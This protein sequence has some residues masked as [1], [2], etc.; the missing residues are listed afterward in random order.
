MSK[1]QIIGQDLNG[2]VNEDEYGNRFYTCFDCGKY[3]GMLP[4]DKLLQ[5]K[6]GLT[7]CK[8]EKCGIAYVAANDPDKPTPPCPQCDGGEA[9]L[10]GQEVSWVE[11]CQ[12]QSLLGL[13]SVYTQIITPEENIIEYDTLRDSRRLVLEDEVYAFVKADV[14]QAITIAR[15]K[16]Y[17]PG[18]GSGIIVVLS[19][20]YTE[21]EK[22]VLD[23]WEGSGWYG[24]AYR[25]LG[26]M[27]SEEEGW[28]QNIA[29]DD[30]K[31]E[32]IYDLGKLVSC[33]CT[34]GDDLCWVGKLD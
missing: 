16:G 34:S 21:L 2:I 32:N 30:R 10:M 13:Y 27:S 19:P 20:A 6:D 7:F 23:V 11:F 8:C 17:T 22:A 5:A 29:A 26:Y 14:A 25:Y 18:D 15:R 12:M 24:C 9:I 1:T 31:C 3:I 28:H 33:C 4:S